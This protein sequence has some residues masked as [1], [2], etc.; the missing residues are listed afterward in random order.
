MMGKNKKLKIELV[1]DTEVTPEV[2]PN[3]VT[4]LF[5][6]R[7]YILTVGD[8]FHVRPTMRIDG[9]FVVPEVTGIDFP[10]KIVGIS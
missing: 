4:V 5:Q 9:D 7:T 8:T 1:T 3:H 2:K 10:I 6:G